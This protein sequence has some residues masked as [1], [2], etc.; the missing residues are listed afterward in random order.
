MTYDTMA[1]P[2]KPVCDTVNFD[3][4]SR[5]PVDMMKRSN[6]CWYHMLKVESSGNSDGDVMIMSAKAIVASP[7]EATLTAFSTVESP[8]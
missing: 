3:D 4:G 8:V 2:A 6:R 1:F 7:R 5:D